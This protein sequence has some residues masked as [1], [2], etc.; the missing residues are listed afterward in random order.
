MKFKLPAP[1]FYCTQYKKYATQL[2]IVVNYALTLMV[3]ILNIGDIRE[4]NMTLST[5][6]VDMYVNKVYTYLGHSVYTAVK[7]FLYL[8]V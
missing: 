1:P 6:L 3:D 7:Y 4:S 8:T 5:L 2:H